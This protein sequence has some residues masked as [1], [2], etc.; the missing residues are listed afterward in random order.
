[1]IEDVDVV[2]LTGGHFAIAT[3]LRR[4]R[5]WWAVRDSVAVRLTM[6]AEVPTKEVPTQRRD[7]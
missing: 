4:R 3:R 7:E 2:A 6:T 5:G 1:M